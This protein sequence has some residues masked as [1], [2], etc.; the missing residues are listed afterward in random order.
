MAI[1]AYRSIN[2]LPPPYLHCFTIHHVGWTFWSSLSRVA[3]SSWHQLMHCTLLKFYPI[4]FNILQGQSSLLAIRWHELTFC[5]LSYSKINDIITN[6]R[7]SFLSMTVTS[8]PLDRS[9]QF[10]ALG[11]CISLVTTMGLCHRLYGRPHTTKPH[12]AK[13]ARAQRLSA[14]LQSSF[15]Y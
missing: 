4:I 12:T 11:Q 8:S 14:V 10:P 9:R 3:A 5:I 2:G 1:M 13:R 15:L 6:N 7:H